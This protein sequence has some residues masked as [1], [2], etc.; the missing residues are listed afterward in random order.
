MVKSNSKRFCHSR[1]MN[2][3]AYNRSSNKHLQRSIQEK[4]FQLENG[5]DSFKDNATVKSLKKYSENDRVNQEVS[6]NDK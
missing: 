3:Y 1:K 6:I 5:E 4:L 2:L